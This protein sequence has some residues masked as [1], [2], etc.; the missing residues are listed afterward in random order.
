[1]RPPRLLLALVAALVAAS[2]LSACA[3]DR[4]AGPDHSG[5]VSAP[6]L[7]RAVAAPATFPASD[8][9]RS[10][11]TA[12]AAAFADGDV[13]AL[14]SLYVEG[15]AAGTS[16]VALLRDY[17]RRGLRVEGMHMQLL[18]VEVLR[19][20]RRLLRLRVTDRLA[21]AVAVGE[22]IR[23]VLPH[24]AASTRVVELRRSPGGRWRVATV[25]GSVPRRDG[26]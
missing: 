13:A 7:A 22:G 20:E 2:S 11:D 17:L 16:D 25:R 1:V 21:G 12:R 10:W 8:V 14:R 15:S 18:A 6:R 24:D 26:R 4:S 3:G 19:E 9:L 5:G 23:V